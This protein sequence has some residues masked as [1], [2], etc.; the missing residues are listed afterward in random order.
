MAMKIVSSGFFA[1][2]VCSFSCAN[3]QLTFALT[4]DVRIL[5]VDAIT[6]YDMSVYIS[7]SLPEY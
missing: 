5:S 3:I 4:T 1:I 7:L 2:C 6:S